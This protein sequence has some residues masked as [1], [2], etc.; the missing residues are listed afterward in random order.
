MTEE[1]IS[2]TL[3]IK[4]V[5]VKGGVLTEDGI[6][7]TDRELAHRPTREDYYNKKTKG[8][9]YDYKKYLETGKL[10]RMRSKHIKEKAASIFNGTNILRAVMLFIGAG[11]TII[12]CRNTTVFLVDYMFILLAVL[13]SSV[14]ILFSVAAFEAA[15]MFWHRRQHLLSIVFIVLW[16]FVVVFSMLTT[17]SINFDSYNRTIEAELEDNKQINSNRLEI[18]SIDNR[19][20]D[21]N[22]DIVF[23]QSELERYKELEWNI[24]AKNIATEI[25]G[26]RKERASLRK[27]KED[28]QKQTPESVIQEDARKQTFFDFLG[29]LLGL[30]GSII[31]FA[32]NVLPAVFID[33]IAPFSVAVSIFLT[34]EYRNEKSS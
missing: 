8:V 29:S 12:S 17:V 4:F 10:Y 7:Y 21:I 24:N 6:L 32:M 20:S 5:R 2:Q 31:Q 15:L 23:L 19:I 26:K 3:G 16:V 13:L 33:L 1:K 14:L 30:Q 27:E 9:K 11:A 18:A 34:E 28:I 22:E 25:S